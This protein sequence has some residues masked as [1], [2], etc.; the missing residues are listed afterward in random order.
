MVYKNFR[1]EIYFLYE[2]AICEITKKLDNLRD[3]IIKPI[4]ID[5]ENK[6]IIYEK[7]DIDLKAFIQEY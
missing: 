7:A 4:D 6:I 3:I 2:K 5:E 1:K